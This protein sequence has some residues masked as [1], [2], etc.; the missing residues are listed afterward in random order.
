MPV[1]RK[2]SARNIPPISSKKHSDIFLSTYGKPSEALPHPLRFGVF[3]SGIIPTMEFSVP[4]CGPRSTLA[5]GVLRVPQEGPPDGGPTGQ[6]SFWVCAV[7]W[8]WAVE[9]RCLLWLHSSKARG[10]GLGI[11]LDWVRSPRI[12]LALGLRH[13]S[14]GLTDL[15]SNHTLNT[16][17]SQH[18]IDDD[19][20]DEE[21][22]DEGDEE[23]D[24]EGE[25]GEDEVVLTDQQVPSP[26]H[27]ASIVPAIALALLT[28]CCTCWLETRAAALALF[29][30]EPDG[31]SRRT[32]S[33]R[34]PPPPH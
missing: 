26:I 8:G 22:E 14:H 32:Y 5:H 7:P 20:D 4:G 11:W 6:C 25:E 31:R 9:C 16:P 29:V 28:V 10:L 33:S 27:P 23:F 24:E 12:H 19:D 3:A 15:W 1:E 17:P 2:K 34:A 13:C 21:D 18:G 30:V